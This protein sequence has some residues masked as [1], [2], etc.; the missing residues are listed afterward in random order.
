MLELTGNLE[1]QVQV[2]SF[3]VTLGAEVVARIEAKIRAS[4]ANPFDGQIPEQLM[5][6]AL[7]K[8]N[9]AFDKQSSLCATDAMS[10]INTIADTQF[11]GPGG[12]ELRKTFGS[13]IGLAYQAATKEQVMKPRE[14]AV[15][16]RAQTVNYLVVTYD[17]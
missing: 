2:D 12:Q 15:A 3:L 13:L 8:V 14:L 16:L 11:H 4:R 9:E 17:L 5:I 7:V 1:N 10:R 6:D